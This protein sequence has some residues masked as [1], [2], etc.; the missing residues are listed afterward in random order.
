MQRIGKIVAA[1]G[2]QG[3]V[4][5][6]HDAVA[7]LHL[8]TWDCLLVELHPQSYIPFFIEEIH[9]SGQEELIC[10]FEEIPNREASHPLLNKAVYT[11]INFTVKLKTEEGYGQFIG[12]EIYDKG[13]AV[14]QIQEVLDGAAQV[15]FKIQSSGR[16]ILIPVVESFIEQID[17]KKKIIFMNLPEG[18]LDL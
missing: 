11:S 18:L 17:S 7:P 4:I 13:Q 5:I 15:L 3:D 10:K 8:N 12:F 2:I 1:H 6:A 9:E 14:G 16:D